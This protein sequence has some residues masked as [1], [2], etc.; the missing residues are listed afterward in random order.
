MCEISEALKERFC[1]DLQL[2]IKI[3]A[4]PYFSERM[5]LYDKH[6]HCLDKYSYFIEMLKSFPTEQDYF[7][8]YNALKERVIDFLSQ[9]TFFI[10]FSTQEDMSKFDIPKREFS[11]KSIYRKDNVGKH[12]ISLD[13]C[14][15]NFTALKHYSPE[16]FGNKGTYEDFIKQFTDNQ[17]F[18]NSK[19]I[20][21]VIFG[22]LNPKRQVKYEEYLM[23][24]VLEDVLNFFPKE[25]IV[26][27]STD[28]IVIEL[29]DAPKEDS[30]VI[31][32]VKD[33]VDK[34]VKKNITIRGE[35]FSLSD[36]GEYDA[37]IKK[38]YYKTLTDT[39]T[40]VIASNDIDIKNANHLIMPIILRKIYHL[41]PSD[42][43]NVFIYEGRLAKFIS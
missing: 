20:R 42:N 13:M 6:F 22:T 26:Y 17:H 10:Q 4:E 16:I 29:D 39:E 8:E 7:A 35:V 11:R 19:Y 23:N 2:P 43:D 28:E 1:K 24:L 14:K 38:V 25:K 34:F 27:F 32:F 12:F 37:Y 5:H 41:P 36:F 9:N 40:S 31:G 3:F 33:T 21:Q 30:T 18:I 15:G